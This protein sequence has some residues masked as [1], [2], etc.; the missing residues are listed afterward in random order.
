M[1]VIGTLTEPLYGYTQEIAM[2]PIDEMEVIE[3]QRRPSQFH[4]KRLIESMRKIGFVTPLI[5][6]RRGEK[7]VVIDGQ[8]RYL[9]AKEMGIEELPCII[10]PD[11]YAHEL[12]EL[13]TEKQM[14]LREKAYV[15]LNVYRWHLDEDP[16]LPEDD[17]KI[18]DSIEYPYFVTLGMGYEK[19]SH[20]FGSAYESLLKRLDIFFSKPLEEAAKLREERAETVLE[21]DRLVREA[22]EKIKE[23]GISHPFLHKEVVSFCNPL[24]RKRKVEETFEEA[25]EI[26]KENLELLIENPE[27]IRAHKFTAEEEF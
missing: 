20:L 7:I 26:L 4:I 1:K 11:T 15:A 18:L 6:I 5:A 23:I 10:I 24:G 16:S 27:R 8:H 25:F 9:A 21:I 19:N 14:T 2:V 12:M 3:I 17:P 22:V 13:N